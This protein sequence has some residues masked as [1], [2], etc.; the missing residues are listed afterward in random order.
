MHHELIGNLHV[1]TVYSDGTACHREVALAAARAGLDF[2]VVTDHNVWVDG[3]E[4]YY[5]GVLLL[6]GEEVHHVRRI[7][8]VNHLLVYG[9]GRELAPFA[10]DPQDLIREATAQGG[11]C[12]LAHPYERRS[13]LSPDL[14]P[15]PW[16]DWGVEGYIGME[17]WNAMSEFKGLL[18]GPLSALFYAYFPSLGL[19]GPFRETLRRWDELLRAGRKVAAVGGAD[20]HGHTYRLGPFRRVVF[21]YEVLFRWVNTHVLVERPLIGDV[22]ADRRV[23]YDALRAGRTWVGYDRL[24]P[25]R[26]FRFQARSGFAQATVGEELARAGA[27]VFEVE[28]P[29]PGSIRLLR[30]GRVVARAYGTRLRFTTAEAGAYRVEVWKMFRGRLRGW[31]FSSPIYCR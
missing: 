14:D 19:K 2:V 7:P 16:M 4:G 17:I 15:I 11:L 30:N 5:D 29:T 10:A 12:F 21:P 31:I 18:R 22:E 24:A 28:T 27:L 6:V 3:L 20:A 9:A 1:H 8:Q 26:G 23:I 25:T 13:P